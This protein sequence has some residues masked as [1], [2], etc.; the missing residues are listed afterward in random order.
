M[1]VDV[2]VVVVDASPRLE[3]VVAGAVVVF[4][5]VPTRATTRRDADAAFDA[6]R[7]V[8]LPI[9]VAL[10]A[11]TPRVVVVPLVFVL[12]A[13]RA[14]G[15]EPQNGQMQYCSLMLHYVEQ[16]FWLLHLMYLCE[17]VC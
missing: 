4:D 5:V 12:V 13:A 10:R 6:L 17:P 1:S 7:A 2:I 9:F 15:L 11:D 14:S 8:A 3:R 16:R